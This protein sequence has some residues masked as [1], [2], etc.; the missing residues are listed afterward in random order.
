[1]N[2]IETNIDRLRD[3]CILVEG[4]TYYAYGTGWVCYKNTDGKH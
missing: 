4:D 2:I 3:P 1:M